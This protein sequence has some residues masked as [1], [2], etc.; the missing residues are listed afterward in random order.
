MRKAI[1]RSK[2]LDAA[3]VVAQRDGASRLT[4]EAVAKEVGLSKA[5]LLYSFPSKD[6]LMQALLQKMIDEFGSNA[7]CARTGLEGD[8]TPQGKMHNK[9]QSFRRLMEEDTHL[10]HAV[11][12]AG[13][14][15]PELLEPLRAHI[16]QELDT[17]LHGMR[18]PVAALVLLSAL[19]GMLLQHL[20][21]LPPVDPDMRRQMLEHIEQS[22]SG[23]E[24]R[25]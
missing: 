22:I 6:A 10:A 13:T 11:L 20:L 21:G 3:S 7:C 19:D 15:N 24:G 23:L 8:Q 2:I 5:G 25:I 4:I 18:N 14:H 12:I 1:S 9:L 17:M 16:T